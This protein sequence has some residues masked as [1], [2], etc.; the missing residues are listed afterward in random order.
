MVFKKE[1]GMKQPPQGDQGVHD[2]LFYSGLLFDAIKEINM[3]G[4][5]KYKYP[6]SY[7]NAVTTLYNMWQYYV[8]GGGDQEPDKIFLKEMLVYE[9]RMQNHID[10]LPKGDGSRQAF[11]RAE[12]PIHMADFTYRAIIKSLGRQKML[13]R[14]KR[15]I[16][17]S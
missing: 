5:E 10:S 17:I 11:M 15:T 7:Y 9:R 1:S 6:K 16:T 13:P 14:K 2:N 8:W 3:L 12:M 4:I